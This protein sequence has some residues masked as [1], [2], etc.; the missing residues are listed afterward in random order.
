MKLINEN[1]NWGLVTKEWHES[2]ATGPFNHV[3]IDN[4]FNEESAVALSKEFLAWDDPLWNHYNNPIEKKK[5]MNAYDKFK[6]NTYQAFFELGSTEI[7]SNL[8][9]LLCSSGLYFDAGLNG[10]GQHSYPAGCNLNAHLD[11]SLHPKLGLERIL[12]II[13]Y[14]TPGWK[15]EYNGGLELWTHDTVNMQPGECVKVLENKF[16]RAVIFQTNQN[17]WH[18]VGI[19]QKVNYPEGVYRNSLAAYYLTDPSLETDSR[20]KALFAPSETQKGNAEILNLIKKRSNIY[21]ASDVYTK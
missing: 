16:N 12:N 3:V 18:S 8:D 13:I 9:R 20:G 4:F 2:T 14:L 5:T 11:Y 7:L 15:P 10:G 17:S 21:A 6:I 19:H 1:I